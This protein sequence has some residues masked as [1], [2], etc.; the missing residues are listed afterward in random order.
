MG[1]TWPGQARDW[2]LPPEFDTQAFLPGFRD[3]Y[4]DW[5]RSQMIFNR[6][7][8]SSSSAAKSAACPLCIKVDRQLASPLH[9]KMK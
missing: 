8:P 4:V 2:Q 6:M 3:Y 9:K 5:M 1:Y 7:P